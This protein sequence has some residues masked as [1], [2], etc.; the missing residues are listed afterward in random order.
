MAA[1]QKRPPDGRTLYLSDGKGVIFDEIS[2]GQVSSFPFS[3]FAQEI[4]D[5]GY[6]SSF[7]SFW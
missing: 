5:V 7:I 1:K 3:G 2:E 4:G 6:N